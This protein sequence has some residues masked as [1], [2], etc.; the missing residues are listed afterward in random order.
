MDADTL[1]AYRMGLDGVKSDTCPFK[2]RRLPRQCLM[3]VDML[4]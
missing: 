4:T 1:I 2:E 3:N